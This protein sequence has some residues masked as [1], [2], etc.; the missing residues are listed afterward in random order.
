MRFKV[1]DTLEV[2]GLASEGFRD[3]WLGAKLLSLH[4]DTASIELSE[5]KPAQ[6]HRA[7]PS[8]F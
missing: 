5:V 7:L 4:G 3:S 8:Q 1:G 6:L 2:S